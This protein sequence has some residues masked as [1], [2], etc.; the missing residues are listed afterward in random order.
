[1]NVP[2]QSDG[3]GKTIS[4]ADLQTKDQRLRQFR[5]AHPLLHAGDVIGNAPELHRVVFKIGDGE[6]RARVGVAG[7]ANGAR[8]E[9]IAFGVFEAQSATRVVSARVQCPYF[10]F[11][12]LVSNTSL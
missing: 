10:Q 1:M 6:T 11:W 3:H 12:Y 8:V 7:L 2:H 9:Q 4:T 5:I